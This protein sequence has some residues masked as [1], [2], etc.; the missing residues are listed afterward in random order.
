MNQ[1]IC[2][3]N[4]AISICILSSLLTIS[5]VYYKKYMYKSGNDKPTPNDIENPEII[6]NTV[7]A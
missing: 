4:L 2:I 6:S 1:E 7:K 5:T 3:T